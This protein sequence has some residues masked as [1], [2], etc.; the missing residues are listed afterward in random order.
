MCLLEQEGLKERANIQVVEAISRSST[1]V[2][3]KSF[4]Y[5][6]ILASQSVLFSVWAI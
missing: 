6:A 1:S 5:N 4:P 3:T 2:V